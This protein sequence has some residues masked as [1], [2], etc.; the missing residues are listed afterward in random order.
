[1]KSISSFPAV[2]A[3]VVLAVG[4]SNSVAAT[5]ISTGSGS[6]VTTV[7]RTA[8]FD[9]L[10][11]TS[12]PLSAYSEDSLFITTPDMSHAGGFTAFLP[13]DPRTTGYH[14]G[15]G[16]NNS[17]TT[18]TPTDNVDFV[19]LEV[20]VGHGFGSL[21]ANVVWETRLNGTTTDSGTVVLFAKGTVLGFSDILGFDELRIAAKDSLTAFGQ[22]QAV[23]LDDLKVQLA[24]GT[25]SQDIPEPG[26]LALF[27]L[28]LAGLGFLRRRRF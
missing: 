6:A 7:D 1:M 11:T 8:T 22:Q 28:G 13:G 5:V 14:L 21:L 2:L 17:F 20:L 15:D 25:G 3:F 4:L 26:T 18:I 19:A 9:G 10:T 16:G 12:V 27:V 24:S 23:A